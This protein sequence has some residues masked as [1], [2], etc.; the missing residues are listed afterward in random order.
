M[1]EPCTVNDDCFEDF[2]KCKGVTS[3]LDEVDIDSGVCEHKDVWPMNAMEWIGNF[4]TIII[5]MASNCGGLG[6]GGS[7]IPVLMIFYGFNTR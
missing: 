3:K 2:E 4:V 7:M 6:G 1:D 5:L